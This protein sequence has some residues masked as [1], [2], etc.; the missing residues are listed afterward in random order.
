MRLMGGRSHDLPGPLAAALPRYPRA[1]GHG[2]SGRWQGVGRSTTR[3]RGAALAIALG[4]A[5]VS[6]TAVYT[7]LLLA[8]AQAGQ[9][10]FYRQRLQVGYASAEAALV[11]AQERLRVDPTYCGDPDPP[12]INGVQV[13]VRVFDAG[14]TTACTPGVGQKTIM[15]HIES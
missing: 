3:E 9:A 10:R 13:D 8:T 1:S 7:M 14:S 6:A 5:L 2:P 4:L 15:A 11:W 12:V